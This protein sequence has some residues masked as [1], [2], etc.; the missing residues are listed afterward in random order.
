MRRISKKK[1]TK[2]QIRTKIKKKKN[3]S[4]MDIDSY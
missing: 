4:G 3:E 1:M 2:R